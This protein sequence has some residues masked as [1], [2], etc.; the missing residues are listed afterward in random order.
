M[1]DT[2]EERARARRRWISIGEVIALGALAIS[3]L[4]L[5]NSWQ[6]G[7]KEPAEVVEEQRTI[8]LVLHGKVL[9]DG[10]RMEITPVEGS[11][12]LESLTVRFIGGAT[13][14]A[15]S[16]GVIG[17]SAV[18]AALPHQADRKGDGSVSATIQVR[19]VEAGVERRSSRTY[20]FKYR[21]EGGGLFGGKSLRLTG[22]SRA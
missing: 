2:P 6:G 20:M 9:D 17:A 4:G 19:Y 7:S 14:S 15:D 21:W 11:H 22:F 1:T 10:R 16:D 8:P 3:A 12:S 13:A 18:E 5:W